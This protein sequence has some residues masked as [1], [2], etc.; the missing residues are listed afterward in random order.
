M[1][2]MKL[3][4]EFYTVMVN[5]VEVT[6]VRHGSQAEAWAQFKRDVDAQPTFAAVAYIGFEE[7]SPV[8]F[9]ASYRVHAD[10]V[11]DQDAQRHARSRVAHL[12]DQHTSP[13]RFQ[14]RPFWSEY[15]E[16]VKHIPES[17]FP[18]EDGPAWPKS[19]LYPGMVLHEEERM[20][21]RARLGVPSGPG[22]GTWIVAGD[23]SMSTTGRYRLIPFERI[24]RE[25]Q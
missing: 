10:P 8:H 16:R 11:E 5:D 14:F 21:R 15:A 13:T 3:E 19:Y 18:F 9:F 22:Q 25:P 12:R 1:S 6:G 2:Q 20:M 7:R 23:G 4:F 17:E 24:L